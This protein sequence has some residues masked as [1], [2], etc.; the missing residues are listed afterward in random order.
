LSANIFVPEDP[1]PPTAATVEQMRR[2]PE[3]GAPIPAGVTEEGTAEL[4][5]RL[6]ERYGSGGSGEGL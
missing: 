5:A 3:T 2:L 6:T 1:V 4:A